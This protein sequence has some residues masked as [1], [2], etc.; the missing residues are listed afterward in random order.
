M[1][2]NDT[3]APPEETKTH[4]DAGKIPTVCPP[5]LRTPKIRARG[6]PTKNELLIRERTS[7]CGSISQYLA[8]NSE[9]K[10]K[11]KEDHSDT[12]PND[13]PTKKFSSTPHDLDK[14]DQYTPV[15]EPATPTENLETDNSGMDILLEELQ[16]MREENARQFS[17]VS[18]QIAGV[19]EKQDKNLD[20]LRRELQKCK[21]ESARSYQELQ[22]QV[23][24]LE[25]KF[26]AKE[27]ANE[28]KIK[29]LEIKIAETHKTQKDPKE[30]GGSDRLQKN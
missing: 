2:S 10:R 7:S 19:S 11:R 23:K 17:G 18:A 8:K 22:I 20:E 30:S 29:E 15:I 24:A 16:K 14:S 13:T 4:S 21:E 6:R 12:S 1:N 27:A 26:S 5:A 28:L 25:Q 3:S 9:A